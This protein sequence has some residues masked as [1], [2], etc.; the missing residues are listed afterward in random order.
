[1]SQIQLSDLSFCYP[2]SYDP[3]FS[4]ISLTLD[5]RWKLGLIGRNGRGKTTLL[6]LLAGMLSGTGHISA[7]INFR[8]FPIPVPEPRRLTADVLSELSG[9]CASW[10]LERELSLLGINTAVLSRPFCSLSPGEQTKV[11]LAALF[12]A[13]NTF[14]L[15]DEP[16]NHLDLEGRQLLGQYLRQKQGFILVSH[17][18]ALL[19]GCADHILAINKADIELQ[20]GNFSS[21]LQNRRQQDDFERTQ[22][23]RLRQQIRHLSK[24]AQRTTGWSEQLEKTKF[25]SSN[26]GLRPDRGYIGHK[27]AKIMRRVKNIERR[28]EAA[29]AQKSTLLHNIERVDDLKLTTLH[30]HNKRLLLLDGVVPCYHGRA[31]CAPVHLSITQGM[32]L[33]ITGKNGTGKSSLLRIIASEPVDYMGTIARTGNVQ[34]S[35]VPQRTDGLSG[36]LS[37]YAEQSHIDISQFFTILRKL[38]FSRV[39]FE[40]DICTF[41]EGQKKKVLIARSL[42]E[43]AHLYLWDEPLNYIDIDSRMQIE[44]LLLKFQ[45]T[46]IFVEHDKTFNDKLSTSVLPLSPSVMR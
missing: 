1:M 12:T 17:D 14:P 37:A 7:N 22:D 29:I 18:R 24:A 28:R 42:C 8:C 40:K 25:G 9:S 46:M 41:S 33:A 44:E 6:H 19:D 2:G 15:I 4:H 3:V 35:Y 45:P 21:W 38:G 26:S 43:Q 16:T 23:A 20:K 36:M 32:R 10:V 34:I 5:D 11:Q 27:S 30:H 39:Q 13:E 31:V